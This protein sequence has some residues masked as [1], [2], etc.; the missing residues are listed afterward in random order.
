MDVVTGIHTGILCSKELKFCINEK[1]GAPG[2]KG[3]SP[4]QIISKSSKQN[5]ISTNKFLTLLQEMKTGKGMVG[6]RRGQL[7]LIQFRQL[8]FLTQLL[9]SGLRNGPLKTRSELSAQDNERRGW[10]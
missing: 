9:H 3:L 1:D 2:K 7:H 6:H 5:F 10:G 4:L 8:L